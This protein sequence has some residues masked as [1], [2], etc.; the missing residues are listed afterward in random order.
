M[1]AGILVAGLGRQQ[2]ASLILAFG[3]ITTGMA[4]LWSVRRSRVPQAGRIIA[5]GLC[6]CYATAVWA[7]VHWQWAAWLNLPFGLILAWLYLSAW[8][9]AVVSVLIVS[10]LVWQSGAVDLMHGTLG[11]FPNFSTIAVGAAMAITGLQ[12]SAMLAWTLRQCVFSG[13]LAT[14]PDAAQAP[15]MAPGLG[16]GATFDG[17]RKNVLRSQIAQALI[18]DQRCVLAN[19]QAIHLMGAGGLHGLLN[20]KFAH[21]SELGVDTAA[22]ST[23]DAKL[24]GLVQSGGGNVLWEPQEPWAPIWFHVLLVAS[25]AKPVALVTLSAPPAGHPLSVPASP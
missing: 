17:L 23:L 24:L 22:E 9:A 5:I 12:L 8:I 10:A 13:L 16:G 14:Q 21:L 15:S 7:D 1:T 25:S 2:V 20:L 18:V 11:D 6:F 19:P 4:A 3:L